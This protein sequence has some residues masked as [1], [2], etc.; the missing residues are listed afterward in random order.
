LDMLLGFDQLLRTQSSEDPVSVLGGFQEAQIRFRPTYKFD[1]GTDKYDSSAKQRKPAW[2]DRILWRLK[3]HLNVVSE[4]YNSKAE[5]CQSDH[6]PVV[7]SLILRP[8]ANYNGSSKASTETSEIPFVTFVT[9]SKWVVGDPGLC[10]FVLDGLSRD[11]WDWIGLFK[12]DFPSLADYHMW[13]YAPP[14][15]PVTFSPVSESGD[16]IFVYVSGDD[17]LGVS[18]VFSIV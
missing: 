3:S 15:S 7:S 1:K 2:C 5:F 11:P 8:L 14:S 13:M 16:F 4:S 6:K 9:P 10:S 18:D 12:K 17:V